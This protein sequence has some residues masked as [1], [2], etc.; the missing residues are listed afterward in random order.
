MNSDRITWPAEWDNQNATWFSWPHRVDTFNFKKEE[1]S[2]AYTEFV[3]TVAKFQK[4]KINASRELF[5]KIEKVLGSLENIELFDHPTNDVWCRDHGATFVKKGD[6]LS[7]VNWRFNGW[8]GKFPPWDLDDKI[9]RIMFDSVC[10]DT[11]LIESELFLEGG[12]IEGNGAGLLLTT[13]AV[14]LNA[15]RNPNWTKSEAEQEFRRCL[16]V[17]HVCWLPAGIQGDDTDGHIDDLTRFIRDDVIL[18]SREKNVTDSN[19]RVLE[20]NRER[21]EGL[22]TL[23]NSNIEVI[24]LPMPDPVKVKNWRL[25]T[26]PASYANFL[27]I[28][29]AV[30]VPTFRQAKKDDR[31]LGIIRE[32]FSSREVIG[33]DSLPFI[34][35]GGALHCLTQQEPDF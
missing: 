26:L 8:G 14:V 19:Y 23:D 30:L 7:A 27:I 28:N 21:L 5:S 22:K 18:T 29:G 34:F 1:F 17:E 31:A 10:K 3:K 16:G 13:E 25:E 33:I 12:A 20:V 2:H 4:V 11:E 6:E 9:A 24:D 32:C 15:N 35:E